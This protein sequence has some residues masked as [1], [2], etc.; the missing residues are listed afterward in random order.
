MF[1]SSNVVIVAFVL[2]FVAVVMIV[3][4]VATSAFAIGDR[5]RRVNRRL[6]LLDT[7]MAPDQ[8][9]TALVRKK[10]GSRI[11]AVA[12]KL[13]D[14]IYVYCRQA[15]FS[16]SPQR[17]AAVAAV[18]AVII[19]LLGTVVLT[20]VTHGAVVVN[21]LVSVVGAIIL[22]VTGVGIWV[23]NRRAKRLKQI[24]EQLPLALDILVRSLRAGHPVSMA[25][26]LSADEMG[27]PIG[28]E[29]G[30]IVDETTYGLELREALANFAH[31][32]GSSYAHFFAVSVAIQSET[33]GNLA[34]ILSNLASII[35]AQL[36]LHLRVKALAAE[37]KMSALILTVLPVLLIAF[38]MLTTPDF[39]TVHLKDP[40]FWPVVGVGCVMYMIGRFI[41]QRIV[42]FR[43]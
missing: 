15:G 31:R 32:T 24:E 6:T 4:A 22:A 28:S 33:G 20:I 3:Q 8:V 27:D 16:I 2:A 13:Y 37:G 25:V 43:Y 17:L 19:G 34:E 12:P 1:S 7:G 38:L 39:Y 5:S 9:Y 30:L 18:L 14:Q 23:N 36:T 21:L 41:I 11:S 35:R 42:N 10:P 40:I 26:K 29:F